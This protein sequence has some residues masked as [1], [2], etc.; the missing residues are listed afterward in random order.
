MRRVLPGPERNSHSLCC[1]LL[2]AVVRLLPFL[3]NP[4]PPDA[5]GAACSD[6]VCLRKPEPRPLPVLAVVA[7]GLSGLQ[8]V[9]LPPRQSPDYSPLA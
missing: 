5:D 3:W 1:L 8:R 9:L 7:T 4:A 6:D 2:R